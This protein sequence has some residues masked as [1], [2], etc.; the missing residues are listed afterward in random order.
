MPAPVPAQLALALLLDHF[1]D[2]DRARRLYQSFKFRVVANWPA[3]REWKITG[4]EI[5]EICAELG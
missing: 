5:D 1:G 3:E 4:S 2:V